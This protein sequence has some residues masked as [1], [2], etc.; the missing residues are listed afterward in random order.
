MNFGFIRGACVSPELVL[1]DCDFNAKKI[2]EEAKA[3][4]G[5][6][7]KIIVFPELSGTLEKVSG[8]CYAAPLPME[9]AAVLAQLKIEHQD[10]TEYEGFQ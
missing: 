2:I 3:A 10:R 4:A 7:A 5:N 9:L 1:A 6:G 8:R